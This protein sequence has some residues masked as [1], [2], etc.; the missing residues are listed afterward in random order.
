M[1]KLPIPTLKDT[2]ESFIQH[3]KALL[4][5]DDFEKTSQQI[6]SFFTDT[7][8]IL[9]TLLE[10]EK[11]SSSTS[12]L[13]K[14]WLNSYLE[15]RGSVSIDSNFSLDLKIVRHMKDKSHEEILN[16]FSTSLAKVCL[17]YA[18]S[19]FDKIFDAR[20]NEICPNHFQI[21]KGS[22]RIPAKDVDRYNISQI[23]SNFIT[24]F[25][26]NNLYK[27]EIFN[28]DE[29][30][31]VKNAILNIL[32]FAKNR[33]NLLPSISFL[34]TQIAGEIRDDL[35]Q[36]NQFFDM[37]ENSLFNISIVDKEFKNEDEKRHFMLY[38][39]GT[40]S[41]MFKPL[42]FIYNLKDKELFINTEHSF[43]DAGSIA[44]ILDKTKENMETYGEFKQDSKEVL[45]PEY[46][47]NKNRIKIEKNLQNYLNTISQL[48]CKDLHFTFEDNLCLGFSKDT[49]MQS[50]LLYTQYKTYGEIRGVY[51]AVDVREYS[52]GRTECVR[53]VSEEA[54][55]FIKALDTS[56]DKA[57]LLEL[58]NEANNRHKTRIK[59]A[60]KAN[61]IDR[62]LFGLMCMANKTDDNTKQKATEFFKGL[63]YGRVSEN[64]ISTTSIGVQENSGYM[65]FAP[66]VADGLGVTYLK[67]KNKI[68]YLLSFYKNMQE[69]ADKFEQ[70]ISI[71]MDKLKDILR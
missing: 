66:V 26:K 43:Q 54:V 30:L 37:V 21:L 50:I 71:G 3:A 57:K 9:Q 12:W 65:L 17:D 40:N 33:E 34:P 14:Y 56:D 22:S 16:I 46:M 25:Y 13:Y 39:D 63:A 28:E 4:S 1:R 61:G 67:P 64:F 53:V 15:T 18:N 19:K 69:K 38:L 31:S 29:I 52:F 35:Y 6:E 20:G 51:E 70:N 36:K 62:H 10:D 49:L 55:E 32:N 11:R 58:L 42:N 44:Y 2:K 48:S 27:I 8:P 60:K 5:K 45:I 68:I 47:D 41:W 59:S 7:A 24:L 23:N